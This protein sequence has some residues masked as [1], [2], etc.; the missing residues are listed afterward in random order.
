MG[1][2]LRVGMEMKKKEAT[3]GLC[4]LRM[5]VPREGKTKGRNGKMKEGSKGRGK[6]D[7]KERMET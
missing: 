6:E 7:A 1:R 3:I 4:A 2:S 5:E